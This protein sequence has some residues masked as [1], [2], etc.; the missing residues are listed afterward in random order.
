M[1]LSGSA[2]AMAPHAGG[3]PGEEQLSSDEKSQI[4]ARLRLTPVERLRYLEDML[5]FEEQAKRACRVT[6]R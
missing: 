1:S 4:A 5:A 3:S 2:C 6:S